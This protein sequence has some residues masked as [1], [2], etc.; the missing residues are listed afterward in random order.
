MR[1]VKLIALTSFPMKKL[2]LLSLITLTAGLTVFTPLQ[3]RAQ[4][5]EKLNLQGAIG[6]SMDIEFRTRKNLDEKGKPQKGV[7]DLY[8]LSLTVAQTTEFK[9][10][11]QRTPAVGG[12]LGTEQKGQL[13]YS[14]DLSVMNPA[15]LSQ[16][17]TVGKWVGT[18]PVRQTANITRK[19]CR[20]AS[21]ASPW[22]P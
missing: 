4:E 3:A 22:M 9:G 19:G 16:K 21:S 6:G 11:I 12:I 14:I 2:H 13:T 17:H 1:V 20:T 7:T 5:L 15:N 10:T 18:V 8:T